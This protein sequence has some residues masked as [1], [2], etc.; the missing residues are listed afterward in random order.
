MIGNEFIHRRNLILFIL[1]SV[2]YF[3]QVTGNIFMEGLGSIFPPFF[4]FIIF[5]IIVI[6]LIHN[7]VNPTVTMY[8][9]I[10]FIYTY[11]YFLLN[12]SPYLVNYLF[13]WLGLP[14]ST[15]Y[16]NVQVV[17]L[18]GVASIILTFYSFFHLHKE[19]FPN[20]VP[21]DFIYLIL[22]GVFIITFLLL[23]IRIVRKAND[24]LQEIAYH[25][26]LTGA[27]NRLLLKNK[28]ELLKDKNVHSISLLFI[29]MNGFKRINDTYGHDVGDQLLERVVLRLNN[30]LRGTDLLCRLGG[31]EFVILSSN[32]N[33]KILESLLERIHLAIAKPIIIDQQMVEISASI[34]WTYTEEVLRAD[35]ENMIREADEAMY[36][37]KGGN[38]H[39]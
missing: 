31:D 17:V 13:M 22:F 35:L 6:L 20:V 38:G 9:M 19:I 18:A 25:D 32:I 36:K 7:K 14:L 21:E 15:I 27:A 30:V 37:E 23:F 39:A 11:F 34:G 33:N 1:I 2:F 4:L 26:P 12:D 16:Q 10:G 8:V 5:G 24:K 28:F 3:T 29:D